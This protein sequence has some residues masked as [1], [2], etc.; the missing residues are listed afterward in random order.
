VL[1][2][3]KDALCAPLRGK[4]LTAAAR[5]GFGMTGRGGGTGLF[6]RTEERLIQAGSLVFQ[7]VPLAATVL[8]KM[9]GAN[10]NPL[11]CFS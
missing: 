11:L 3:V 4:S 10:R 9:G 8:A 2:A 1:T 7:V 5:G 6:D